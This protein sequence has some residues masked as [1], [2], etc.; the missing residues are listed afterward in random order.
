MAQRKLKYNFADL[1]GVIFGINTSLKHKIKIIKIIEEKCKK[2]NR[3]N[4]KFF[5]AYYSKQTGE[6]E[7]KELGILKFNAAEAIPSS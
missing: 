1:E 6:I 2:E 3:S 7:V 5:Q 4:F